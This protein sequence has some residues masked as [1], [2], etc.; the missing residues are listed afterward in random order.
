MVSSSSDAKRLASL[1]E[2]S[3]VASRKLKKQ[4]KKSIKRHD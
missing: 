4:V 2:G 3:L 1:M